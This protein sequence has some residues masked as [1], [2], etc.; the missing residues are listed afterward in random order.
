MY[1]PIPVQNNPFGKIFYWLVAFATRFP[2]HLVCV[3]V[4][5]AFA[6]SASTT[7]KH[8]WRRR[9]KRLG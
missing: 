3:S 1:L 2:F 5:C 9:P 6:A 8:L 4:L 7:T